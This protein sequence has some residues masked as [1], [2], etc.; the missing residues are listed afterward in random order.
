MR[1]AVRALLIIAVFAPLA[2]AAD[3]PPVIRKLKKLY[4]ETVLVENGS[5]RAVIVV[6]DG[7]TYLPQAKNL[8]DIIKAES[9][10][11]LAI[12]RAGELV[13]EDWHVDV[14]GLDGKNL[15]ALGN[16]N[17][18]LL[19]TSLYGERYV[20]ADSIYP[21]KGGHV[22]RTVHDPFAAGI[23]VLVLA[24]SDAEGVEKAVTIFGKKFVEGAGK[25][26]ALRQPVIDVEFEKKAYRFFPDA[27]HVLSSKR[28]PQYTGMEWFR[29]RLQEAGFMDANSNVIENA[30]KNLNLVALTGMIARIGKTY[31]R[32][33]RAELPPLMKELLDKNRQMLKRPAKVED[34]GGRSAAHVHEWDLLE[35]LPIWTDRD[36]LEITNALLMD[37]SLGHEPRVFH[38]QV[39]QGCVQAMDENHGTN[40]ALKSFQAWQYFHKYYDIPESDYWM[41]CAD[42]VFSAQAS[43]F[44]ILEDAAGYLCYCPIHTVDYSFARRNFT[45]LKRGIAR[46]HARYVSLA[47]M[48][49]LGLGTG[50]GDSSGILY[51]SFF[52][53]L[54][55][56][57]WYHRDPYL[58]WIVR[59]K[60][61][62]GCGLRIFQKSIAVDLNVE[63]KEPSEWTG[64]IRVPLYEAPIVKG[65]GVKKAVFAPKKDVDPKLFNK[66]IFK[67]NWDADGQYL[68]LDGAG[69]WGG[70]PGPHGH[71]HNDIN[72]IINF[73]DDGRMW[74][75][76]HT[77]QMRAL[78][79][80]SGLYFTCEGQGG[81]KKRTLA[82]LLNFAQTPEYGLT[83]SRFIN[84]E[85]AIFWKKGLYF[86]L[87][88]RGI[89]DKDGEFFARCSWRTL[90][91]EQLRGKDLYL[92]QEGRH[93]KIVSDGEANV[94]VE[95]YT[96]LDQRQWDTFYGHA[97]PVVKI[98]QQDKKAQLK[99]GECI[100]FANLLY[101]YPSKERED[102][103]KMLPVSGG[104]VLV[105]EGDSPTVMGVGR[106]PGAV[107]EAEM[108]VVSPGRVLALGCGSLGD[109][110]IA[111]DG[112]CDLVVDTSGKKLTVKTGGKLELKLEGSVS[113]AVEAG[114]QLALQKTEGGVRLALTPGEHDISPRD[115][116]G[117]GRLVG[118]VKKALDAARSDAEKRRAAA[119]AGQRKAEAKGIQIET[120]R[121]DMYI[122]T[123][124]PADVD[125]DGADEWVVGGKEG[126]GVYEADGRKLWTFATEGS[127]RTA[128]VGDLDADGRPEIV[129]GCDDRRVHALDADGK[130]KW[131]FA[132]KESN[133]STS[134]PPAV[135]YVE[136]SDLDGDG[137]REVV[138]GANWVHVLNGDGTLRWEK[139]M[140]FR[141][142]RICGDFIC[143]TVA[144]LDGDGRK[145]ITALFLTSYPLLQIFNADGKMIVP[146]GSA[147]HK[148]I[149][150]GVPKLVMALDLFGS[151]KEKQ[152]VVADEGKLRFFWRDQKPREQ[153]G[154]SI[155]GCFLKAAAFRADPASAPVIF[156]ANDICGVCAVKPGPRG[157]DRRIK[158]TQLWYRTLDEKITALLAADLDGDGRGELYVGTKAGNIHIFKEGGEPAGFA[159]TF[160]AP[161]VAMV[162]WPSAKAVL[163]AK[164]DG[165][166]LVLRL[167][168]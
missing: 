32:T 134:S 43:T 126:L 81:Y 125:G 53:L 84:W 133:P 153:A 20:V 68:L 62:Q 137:K 16:V 78:K 144:D 130:E 135:D 145:E 117:F 72:T 8:Q 120:V 132:C 158:S 40:S 104:C 110:I 9:G 6:P 86:V 122:E 157:T 90:G 38:E 70:P 12:R 24:G 103:V 99:Q 46:H 73:T 26:I 41:R 152:I 15:I 29:E 163:A 42:A 85:R 60:L 116:D 34:M 11:E 66:I 82:E 142:N 36:R 146:V 88:D 13:D 44:Q 19:L 67:E 64:L 151:G 80:H 76:D 39:K 107:G 167:P 47:C 18:N 114:G 102:L 37:A 75:V 23:N 83:R 48:N 97:E 57:A 112:T 30:N 166:V 156:A 111:A 165:S 50:F 52:E 136:I 127:V 74:L 1:L 106:M 147:P 25:T 139:Y 168:H 54:A 118:L 121:L 155:G 63:P 55:P 91:N 128:D 140:D 141:R 161:V 160:G 69:T 21:G 56:I 49:N 98:F 17:D 51:P 61:P 92:S 149:N 164:A 14:R 119:A 22:I 143:G 35:E 10:A 123:I 2:G 138:A 96:F 89:A 124:L 79:E 115:W 131:T 77:Y 108:F 150:I 58:Y 45:Y 148:G 59:N 105:L 159:R 28:Q 154:G 87:L 7:N 31:F 101:A 95:R 109:G 33:G 93:C 71:K 65:Q 113:S 27:S 162:S 94:D 5:P 3:G 100:S 4:P 129:F